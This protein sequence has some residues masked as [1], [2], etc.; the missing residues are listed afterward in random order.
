MVYNPI[1]G[2]LLSGKIKS[3]D[4]VPDDGRFSDEAFSGKVYRARYY[5]EST[6]KAV[7]TIEKAAQAAGLSMVEVALRW[8]VHHS[9]LSIKG[10]NDGILVGASSLAQLESNLTD[11]EKGPLPEPVLAAVDEAWLTAKPDVAPYWHFDLKYGY[12]TK[13][14][15]FG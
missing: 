10:G 7:Q 12:D 11:L 9:E 2:G 14:A 5:R 4:Q 6:F 15:L 13:K 1:A 8:L 3:V